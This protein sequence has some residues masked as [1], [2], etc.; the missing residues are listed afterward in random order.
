MRWLASRLPQQRHLA[1][2][3]RC[4]SSAARRLTSPKWRSAG[5]PC[6][7]TGYT[8]L[9]ERVARA[10]SPQAPCCLTNMPL[11]SW[12][13]SGSGSD[14][15]ITLQDARLLAVESGFVFKNA[16]GSEDLPLARRADL[17]GERSSGGAC[18]EGQRKG[19]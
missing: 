13:Q 1:I 8:D 6:G 3:L 7:S 5:L 16:Q 15:P 17:Q 2:A 19:A 10:A 18:P 9:F 11:L 12:E 14:L 4:A